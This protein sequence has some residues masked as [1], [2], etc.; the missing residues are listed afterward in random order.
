MD[1]SAAASWN[2]LGASC[3]PGG[4]L[5]RPGAVLGS[6]WGRP[7]AILGSP[8]A[9]WGLLELPGASRDPLGSPWSLLGPPGA[10]RS[11]LEPPPQNWSRQKENSS[12]NFG[13]LVLGRPVVLLEAQI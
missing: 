1:S 10:S 3:P 12:Y 6:S 11:L 4:R 2:L 7:G 8:G 9:S 13:V 5:G